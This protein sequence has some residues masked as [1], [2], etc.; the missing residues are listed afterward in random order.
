MEF[1]VLILGE[2]ESFDF[3]GRRSVVLRYDKK[4]IFY[5]ILS[6]FSFRF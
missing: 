4:E 2:G 6:S 1:R 3:G 5:F